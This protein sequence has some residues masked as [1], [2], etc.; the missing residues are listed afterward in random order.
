MLVLAI[1]CYP[2]FASSQAKKQ[3]EKDAPR[4]EAERKEQ[5]RLER[6]ADMPTWKRNLHLAQ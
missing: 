5:E 4:L 1:R 6:L 3:A 2:R